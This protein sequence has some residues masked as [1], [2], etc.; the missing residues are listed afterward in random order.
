[1]I[2]HVINLIR[3]IFD[4]IHNPRMR[5][6]NINNINKEA[7]ITCKIRINQPLFMF[8]IIDIIESEAI[9]KKSL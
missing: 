2:I 6:N 8:I 3:I 5:C 7:P 9:V 4:L 1:M